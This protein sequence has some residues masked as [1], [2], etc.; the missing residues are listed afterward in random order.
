MDIEQRNILENYRQAMRYEF[1][2]LQKS[3][4]STEFYLA[5][6]QRISTLAKN[7]AAM[8]GNIE[9]QQRMEI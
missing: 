8:I 2:S 7:C 4:M 1:S 3:G 9:L 5:S 6:L